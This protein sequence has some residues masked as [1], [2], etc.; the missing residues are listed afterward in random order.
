MFPKFPRFLVWKASL[1][2]AMICQSQVSV[3]KSSKLGGNEK[4]PKFQRVPKTMT[5]FEYENIGTKS[6]NMSDIMVYLAMFSTTIDT[7]L[8][9]WVLITWKWVIILLVFGTLWNLDFF[10]FRRPPPPNFE[11]F[12][13]EIWVFIDFLT[14]PQ[15]LFRRFLV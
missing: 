9:F 5:H 12:P 8:C 11:L 3:G 10:D 1:S 15:P 4:S 6:V 7:I 13:T 2:K 14:T